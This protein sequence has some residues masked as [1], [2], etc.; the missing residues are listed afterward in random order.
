MELHLFRGDRVGD[1]IQPGFPVSQA[2]T[3]GIFSKFVNG[4][5]SESLANRPFS[6]QIADHVGHAAGTPAEAF[7]RKSTLISFTK[8]R[9][10]A[11]K[12]MTGPAPCDVE[13]CA[14]PDATHFLYELRLDSTDLPEA[15]LGLCGVHHLQYRWSLENCHRHVQGNPMLELVEGFVAGNASVERHVRHALLVDVVCF[16][17]NHGAMLDADTVRRG[18]ERARRDA[19]WLLFPAD[20]LEDGSGQLSAQFRPNRHLFMTGFKAAG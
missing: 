12:Y 15:K 17:E 5:S 13:L 9:E 7:M 4:G 8:N 3:I 11:L 2:L 1:L 20:P 10:T 18:L 16:L 6:V 19:E 14:F